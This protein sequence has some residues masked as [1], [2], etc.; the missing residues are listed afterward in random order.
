MSGDSWSHTGAILAGGRS[1][2]FGSPKHNLT[3]ANGATFL[4]SVALQLTDVCREVV[5]VGAVPSNF[6]QIPDLRDGYGPLGGI[7]AL[8]ASGLDSEYLVCPV[9]MPLI[10]AALLRLLTRPAGRPVTILAVEGSAQMETLPVRIAAS[11]L[12]QVT[13]AL[14]AGRPAL[15][16]LWAD[17][18]FE[19]VVIPLSHARSLFNVNTRDDYGRLDGPSSL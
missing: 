4:E 10:P 6:Q 17:L 14:D 19:T 11:A 9:D 8:L 1:S 15:H 7:E 12:P 13:S 3:L 5:V 2:R 16:H 18:G